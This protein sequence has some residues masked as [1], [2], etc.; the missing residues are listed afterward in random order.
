MFTLEYEKLG[1]ILEIKLIWKGESKIEL[2]PEDPY[3]IVDLTSE[4]IQNEGVFDTRPSN[5]DFTLSWNKEFIRI[6]VAK[7]GD[8]RGGSVT[9]ETPTTDERLNSLSECLS[10]WKQL[11]CSFSAE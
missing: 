9:I 10:L 8:G 1:E 11:V 2:I 5:G 6:S 7:Y 4:Q 3:E